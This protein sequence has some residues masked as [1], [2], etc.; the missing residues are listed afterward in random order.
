[1]TDVNAQD[2]SLEA[3][4][5]LDFRISQ[6]SSKNETK[7][8]PKKIHFDTFGGIAAFWLSSV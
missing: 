8:A 5:A 1:M 6:N 7:I 4:I 3:M 2:M